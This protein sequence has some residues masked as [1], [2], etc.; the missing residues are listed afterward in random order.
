MPFELIIKTT[1]GTDRFPSK[2]SNG[3][4]KT[5]EQKDRFPNRRSHEGA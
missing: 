2:S 3:I 5:T 4:N 1:G